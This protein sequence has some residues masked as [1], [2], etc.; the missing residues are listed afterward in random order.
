M[1]TQAIVNVLYLISIIVLIIGLRRLSSPATARSGNFVAALGMGLAIV[2]ALFM[3]I[4]Y[5]Y[6]AQTN[7][8][9]LKLKQI[10]NNLLP[11]ATYS[12]IDYEL[13]Y[14]YGNVVEPT[15]VG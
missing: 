2:T 15:I 10:L 12:G 8:T 1:E 7:I 9:K 11:D 4:E 6:N 3:P 14:D 13:T 5:E